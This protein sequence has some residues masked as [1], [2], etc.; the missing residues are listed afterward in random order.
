MK[1]DISYFAKLSHIAVLDEEL[2]KFEQDIEEAL[3]NFVDLSEFDNVEIKIDASNQIRLRE[4][5]V[6]PSLTQ[7]E[8]LANAPKQSGGCIVIPKTVE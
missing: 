7:N 6:Q 4:D 3:E 1:I 8:A 2:P 5:K